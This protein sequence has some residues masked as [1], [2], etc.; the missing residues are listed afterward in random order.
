[1]R[2]VTTASFMLVLPWM[3]GSALLVYTV[4]AVLIMIATVLVAKKDDRGEAFMVLVTIFTCFFVI[5][6]DIN[7]TVWALTTLFVGALA[8]R[9]Q[10]KNSV[11]TP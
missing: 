8:S 5:V 2:A 9:L 1:M 4:S 6:G 7:I 10:W 11:P 3:G